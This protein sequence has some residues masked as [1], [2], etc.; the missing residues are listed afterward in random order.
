[1]SNASQKSWDQN[2][3][4]KTAI[5]AI[6]GF[7]FSLVFMLW[8]LVILVRFWIFDSILYN[9]FVISMLTVGIIFNISSINLF[10]NEYINSSFVLPFILSSIVSIF[11]T[12]FC[13]I[14]PIYKM[15]IFSQFT[16]MP[17]A[18]YD[19][20][21]YDG[22]TEAINATKLHPFAQRYLTKN[23]FFAHT[24]L[25]VVLLIV[26][27]IAECLFFFYACTLYYKL[28]AEETKILKALKADKD[29]PKD[30]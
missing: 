3:E 7:I 28:R 30:L 4:I 22:L 11:W 27:A 8:S 15:D 29:S 17:F 1:M 14:M 5:L 16:E 13:I 10:F 6:S 2:H 18:V 24:T 9:L 21:F 20:S 26:F 19:N 23:P 12:I 25:I